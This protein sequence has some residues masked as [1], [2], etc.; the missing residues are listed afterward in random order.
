MKCPVCNNLLTHVERAGV[1]IDLCP[2][3]QGMWL[4]RGE[5]DKIIERSAAGGSASYPGED[6]SRRHGRRQEDLAAQFFDFG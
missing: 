1:A 5:L 3:C 4:D 6:D 2:E